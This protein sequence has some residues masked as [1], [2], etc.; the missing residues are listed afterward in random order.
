MIFLLLQVTNS[1]TGGSI[2]VSNPFSEY[3]KFLPLRVLVPT[4]WNESER[5]I[6]T[7]TSLEAALSAKLNSLDREFTL[8]R[9]KTSSVDWC[10]ECWWDADSGILTFHD[11]KTVDAMYRSRALDLP[12]VSFFSRSVI[13]FFIIF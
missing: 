2:G 1:A 8:L 11:W 5:A 7:G 6:I 9:E 13:P 3:V 12:G 10:Q 4:F